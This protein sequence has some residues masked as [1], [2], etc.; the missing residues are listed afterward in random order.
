MHHHHH[1][2]HIFFSSH[3]HYQCAS[4]LSSSVPTFH[5]HLHLHSS[6]QIQHISSSI[7]KSP[8]PSWTIHPIGIISSHGFAPGRGILGHVI[9]CL[10]CTH[11]QGTKYTHDRIGGDYASLGGRWTIE[12][13]LGVRLEVS[14]FV[15]DV[16]HDGVVGVMTVRNCMHACIRFWFSAFCPLV[17]IIVNVSFIALQHLLASITQNERTKPTI[18]TCTISGTK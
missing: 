9:T 4:H 13:L 5:H 14:L 10:A 16:D 12:C 18:Y 8:S 6:I 17:A 11:A 1:H 2:H 7:R 15:D 3:P